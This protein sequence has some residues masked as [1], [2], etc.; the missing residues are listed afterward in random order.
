MHP[1]YGEF[2]GFII[3]ILIIVFIFYLIYKL[4]FMRNKRNRY[5]KSNYKK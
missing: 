5:D 1:K 4:I 2:L 3:S